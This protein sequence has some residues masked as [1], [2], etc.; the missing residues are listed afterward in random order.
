[1]ALKWPIMC[2]CAVKKLLTHSL[3]HLSRLIIWNTRRW[4][5]YVDGQLRRLVSWS[6]RLVS[7]CF[8]NSIGDG[9]RHSTS[10]RLV[11]RATR[12]RRRLPRLCPRRL[13]W[14]VTATQTG[15]FLSCFGAAVWI[16]SVLI[17]LPNG[18]WKLCW[19]IVCNTGVRH[20][21][22]CC[23]DDQVGAQFQCRQALLG[24]SECTPAPRCVYCHVEP[25]TSARFRRTRTAQRRR[26][27]PATTRCQTSC[28]VRTADAAPQYSQVAAAPFVHYLPCT[29]F[30][31]HE[32]DAI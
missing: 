2:W 3:T 28:D 19:G 5:H 30:V 12:R 10:G 11:V 26:C 4:W 16:G 24:S 17:H 8:R 13:V 20:R 9:R 18:L 15:Q 29:V 27:S 32:F 1:M 6:R 7:D 31:F 21:P 25:M 23:G 22:H 14:V